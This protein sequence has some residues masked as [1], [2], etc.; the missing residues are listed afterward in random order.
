[1]GLS[2]KVASLRRLNVG[3]P[4]V[5]L[6]PVAVFGWIPVTGILLDVHVEPGG[7]IGSFYNKLRLTAYRACWE[8][9]LAV[10]FDSSIPWLCNHFCEE[11]KG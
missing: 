1:M 7:K 2:P 11:I 9:F 6:R 4:N 10:F 3:H 5:S 8:I